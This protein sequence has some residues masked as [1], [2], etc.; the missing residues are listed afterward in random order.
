[1]TCSWLVYGLFL[2]K[3]CHLDLFIT[4]SSLLHYLFITSSLL[5]HHFFM[6]YSWLDYN[7]FMTGW[8]LIHCSLLALDLFTTCLLHVHDVHLVWS[9]LSSLDLFMTC[10]WLAHGLFTTCL[11]IVYDLIISKLVHHLFTIFSWH[12]MSCLW[13]V[14]ELQMACHCLLMTKQFQ[15]QY[16]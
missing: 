10:S 16:L 1:M 14:H 13:L 15:L 5:A 8:W 6:T 11:W 9:C 2:T 7:L 3:K 4:C 12:I